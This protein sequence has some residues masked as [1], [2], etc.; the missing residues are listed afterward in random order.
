MLFSYKKKK[1]KI[2]VKNTGRPDPTQSKTRLTR[3]CFLTSLK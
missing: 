3:T 2:H 1:K